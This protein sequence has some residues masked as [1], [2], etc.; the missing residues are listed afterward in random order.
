MRA[1][2]SK[3]IAQARTSAQRCFLS[4]SH[5]LNRVRGNFLV[6]QAFQ[7]WLYT[8]DGYPESRD[9]DQ[10]YRV[11]EPSPKQVERTRLFL[12]DGLPEA[13]DCDDNYVDLAHPEMRPN[14]GRS[15][16]LTEDSPDSDELPPPE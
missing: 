1:Q 13:R 10:N 15:T 9:C 8:D 5:L 3:V 14:Q 7:P 2:C 12:D 11:L 4:A 16:E 6:M